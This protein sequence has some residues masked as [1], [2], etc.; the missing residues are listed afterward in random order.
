MSLRLG[1]SIFEWLCIGENTK[2][3]VSLKVRSHASMAMFP[4]LQR[5]PEPQNRT[6]GHRSTLA[7]SWVCK[8]SFCKTMRNQIQIQIQN[9]VQNQELFNIQKL[10]FK[11]KASSNQCLLLPLP[12]LSL[13]RFGRA[14]FLRL[15][16]QMGLEFRA[17]ALFCF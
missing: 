15:V 1:V 12:F 9:H 16:N 17:E 5:R 7:F 2:K 6:P 14:D 8:Q 11:F 10:K 3:R 13:A 4:L